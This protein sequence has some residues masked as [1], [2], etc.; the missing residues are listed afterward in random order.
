MNEIKICEHRKIFQYNKFDMLELKARIILFEKSNA[1]YVKF[2]KTLVE[3]QI[4]NKELE[5]SKLEYLNL[6][7]TC[8]KKNLKP[9]S[10]DIVEAF[11]ILVQVK[12]TKRFKDESE[13]EIKIGKVE[14]LLM[15][16]FKEKYCGLFI[17]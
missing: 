15:Y 13:K 2:I 14:E 1:T 8:N 3:L 11:G 7:N 9:F 17:V 4:C 10:N 5:P 12:L 16:S 6:N